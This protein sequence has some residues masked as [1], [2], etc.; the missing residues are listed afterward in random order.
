MKRN[1]NNPHKKPMTL[2]NGSAPRHPTSGGEGGRGGEG[3]VGKEG[4]VG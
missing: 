4:E 1:V 2:A 3:E